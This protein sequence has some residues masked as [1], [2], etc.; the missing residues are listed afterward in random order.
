MAGK[1]TDDLLAAGSLS[2]LGAAL[3]ERRLSVEAL[4]DWHLAR[5]AALNPALNAVRETAPRA[6]E[7]ARRADAEIAAGRLRGSR[8]GAARRR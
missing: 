2:E 1:T 4:V 7:D 8:S 5:I 6:R 3:R